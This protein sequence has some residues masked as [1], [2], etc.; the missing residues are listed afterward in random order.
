MKKKIEKGIKI[1]KI[2]STLPSLTTNKT[3]IERKNLEKMQ[4][5]DKQKKKHMQTNITD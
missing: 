1:R 5:H 2:S 4:S 3:P